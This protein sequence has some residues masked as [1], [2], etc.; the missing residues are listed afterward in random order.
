MARVNW[1]IVIAGGIGLLLC[2]LLGVGLFVVWGFGNWDMMG[3][4]MMGGW[5]YNPLGWIG[6]LLM[7]L[8]PVGILVLAIFGVIALL[9]G[10]L[11]SSQGRLDTY[12]QSEDQLTAR[13]ILQMRYARGEIS[14][15]EYQQ[16]LSDIS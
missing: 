4:G 7:W 8:I 3:P 13:E 14:R 12:R 5:G 15:E 1:I 11:S 2:V 16:M 9:S 10:S 6:M